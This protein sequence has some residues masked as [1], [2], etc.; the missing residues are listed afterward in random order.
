MAF[1]DN[2]ESLIRQLSDVP[3][4]SEEQRNV[5]TSD[6]LIARIMPIMTAFVTEQVTQTQAVRDKT[7]EKM[8]TLAEKVLIAPV[9]AEDIPRYL[10]DI[11]EGI[12]SGDW[13]ENAV[14]N[15]AEHWFFAPIFTI[16]I[17]G[18]QI[19]SL[20]TSY[21]SVSNERTR[22]IANQ[23]IRPHLLDLETLTKEFFRNTANR[24]WVIEQ[25]ERMGI[26]DDKINVYLRNQEYLLPIDF[27]RVLWNREFI[28]DS[29][30]DTALEKLQFR[31]EDFEDIK[32]TL[33]VYPSTQDLILFAIREVFDPVF[34]E[35][36]GLSADMPQEFIDE[37]LKTG[38]PEKYAAMF[39]QAHW[40]P[41]SGGEAFEM[42]HRQVIDIDELKTLLRIQ[43]IMPGYRDKLIEIAYNPITRV[44]IR[45][46][47]ADGIMGYEEMVRK[48]RDIGY[49]PENAELLA[50][51]TDARYGEES[52]ERTRGDILK[53]FKL[54]EYN[55]PDTLDALQDIGYPIE[56]AE[57]YILRVELERAETHKKNQLKIW[58]KG[59]VNYVYSDQEVINLMLVAGI[60]K[61]EVADLLN[62]WTVERD[63]KLKNLSLE[64][65]KS[66]YVAA[67]INNQGVA[68]RLIVQGY[69]P[70]DIDLLIKLWGTKSAK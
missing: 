5:L 48:Y 49:S 53:L 52:K 8:R 30:L 3:E 54:G 15:I 59:F 19:V 63:S 55:R 46:I 27:L 26:S 33:K 13:L 10:R 67:L 65:I 14:D 1:A 18:F 9:G 32:K 42:F 38:L 51:W 11:Q 57:E 34:A 4:L 21:F 64:V 23:Q 43:D 69:D 37:A 28:D 45:R 31:P 62:D 41:P 66:L 36:A 17:A 50:E 60:Q 68:T 61:I 25:I 44:D 70:V 7:G 24:E 58:R 6:V 29:Q 47:Y 22:Q 35:Q 12:V 2:L 20:L 56:I 40:R 16:I 39:W